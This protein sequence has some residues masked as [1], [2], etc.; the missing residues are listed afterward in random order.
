M[1][2]VTPEADP[3]LTGA[4]RVVDGRVTMIKGRWDRWGTVH[5]GGAI[6]FGGGE[7]RGR[8]VVG[9]GVGLRVV[10]VGG[11]GYPGRGVLVLGGRGRALYELYDLD[12]VRLADV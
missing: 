9:R 4:I 7:G 2:R 8:R 5:G 1:D 6:R 12:G 11:R 10:R 3:T